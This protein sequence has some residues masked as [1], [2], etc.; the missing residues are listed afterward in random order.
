VRPNT[1]G[2]CKDNSI[3]N[4]SINE[5]CDLFPNNAVVL[6]APIGNYIGDLFDAEKEVVANAVEC[7]Q[8]E[9]A[10]GRFLAAAAL[11]Q[12][13]IIRQPI[14]RGTSNEPVWPP[15]IVG[16]ISHNNTTCI[17]A[18]ASNSEFSGIGVDLEAGDADVSDTANLVLRM[19]ERCEP[20]ELNKT[21]YQDL[22][23][24]SFS[25]KESIYK[26]IYPELRRF[27]EFDEVRIKF[28]SDRKS[29]SAT[30]PEDESL[31]N[32]LALGTGGYVFVENTIVT[33]FILARA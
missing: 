29:F 14:L 23:R 1:V 19:D 17:V 7:R 27:V 6:A 2:L 21:Q 8:F 24:L 33:N 32:M 22:V 31:N 28:H 3:E 12:L 9:F 10:T 15:G 20:G 26:A 30:A 25:A 18:V 11:C 16:S 4:S 13:G 5:V